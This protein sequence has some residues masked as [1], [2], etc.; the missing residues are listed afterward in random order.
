MQWGGTGAHALMPSDE[1]LSQQVSSQ[2]E[3]ASGD[4]SSQPGIAQSSLVGAGHG[5]SSGQI[6]ENS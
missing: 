1:S 5:L 4:C 3:T 6:M 2:G